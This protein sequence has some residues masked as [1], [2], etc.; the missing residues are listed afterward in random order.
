MLNVTSVDFYCG[1][2]TFLKHILHESHGH[3]LRTDGTNSVLFK[4]Y[5]FPSTIQKLE[6]VGRLFFGVLCIVFRHYMY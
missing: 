1:V 5:V 2:Q 4:M 6:Q 3:S